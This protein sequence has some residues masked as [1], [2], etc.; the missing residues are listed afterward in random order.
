MTNRYLVVTGCFSNSLSTRA[1]EE[2][3]RIHRLEPDKG[4]LGTFQADPCPT[5]L[6]APLQRAHAH[7][8]AGL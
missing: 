1:R 5:T 2:S 3:Y 7:E 4:L 6:P 8:R